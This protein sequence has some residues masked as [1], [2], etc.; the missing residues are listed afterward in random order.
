[1]YR[2]AN[3]L[4]GGHPVEDEARILGALVGDYLTSCADDRPRIPAS[5][6]GSRCSGYRL[7]GE[8]RS[9]QIAAKPEIAVL[10]CGTIPSRGQ[11]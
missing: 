11:L 5:A 9:N 1:M 10:D 3:F 8:P 7:G 4:L 2:T 6:H